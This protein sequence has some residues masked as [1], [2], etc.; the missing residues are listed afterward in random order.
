[1]P[2]RADPGHAANRDDDRQRKLA[3]LRARLCQEALALR[4]PADWARPLRMAALMPGEEF[5]NILLICAQRPAATMMRDYRQWA[6]IG[7]QVR[8]RE[9]G[10]EVFAIPS[11]QQQRNKE[12][13]QDQQERGWR[14]ADRVTYLWD[15]SQTTGQPLAIPGSLPP[16]GQAPAG[17][18]NTLR[19]LARREGFAVEHEHGAPADGTTFWA[20][21]RIRLLPGLSDD[22]A[23]WALAHQLGH[24]LL[25]HGSG[26]PPGTTTSGCAG[27][28]KAE[29]DSIA[30]I[31]TARH[32][33]TAAAE[34]AH[35]VSWAGND[36]RAQPA[37]VIL[38]TGQRIT[39]AAARITQHTDRILHGDQPA[40]AVPAPTRPARLMTK[41]RPAERG[42]AS[43]PSPAVGRPAV[44]RPPADPSEPT[45][46]IL[47]HAQ[48]FYAAQLGGSWAA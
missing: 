27:I 1:M 2:P 21:R 14:T 31:V 26:L 46:R 10:I 32:G 24:I 42:G 35:P 43:A 30:F 40:P 44:A 7:R 6:S 18:P 45:R 25:D 28:R 23:A 3:A 9:K 16:P 17:L 20:A 48:D 29:A 22:Q 37:A 38:T 12:K 13:D 15:L 5:A 47:Q 34:L 8:R 39:T 19:W 4:A 11:D 41:P 33:I 36:P